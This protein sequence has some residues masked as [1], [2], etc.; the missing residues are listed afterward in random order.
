MYIHVIDPIFILK[1]PPPPPPPPP[2]PLPILRV[3]IL[4]RPN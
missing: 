4:H 3:F 2:P 1:I